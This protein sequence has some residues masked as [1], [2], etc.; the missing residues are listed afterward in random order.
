MKNYI[1]YIYLQSITLTMDIGIISDTH[2]SEKR[3]KLNDK[4]FEVFK[5]VDLILH[6][7]DIT[8]KKVLNDLSSIAPVKAVLGNNDKLDLKKYEI[9]NVCNV[10]I[11]LVHGHQTKDLYD[12]A[13]KYNADII[14]SGHTHKANFEKHNNIYL[15]NP[16][17]AS[18]PIKSAASIAILKIKEKIEVKFFELQ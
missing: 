16:G 12:F 5:D 6:A 8:S 7:G 9:I 13:L 14:I 4:I 18:K 11:I 17:S 15:I 10:K 1:F 3:G 2:I